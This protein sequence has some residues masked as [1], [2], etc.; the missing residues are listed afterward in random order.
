MD[1]GKYICM[2]VFTTTIVTNSTDFNKYGKA[3]VIRILDQKLKGIKKYP[4]DD[5]DN[6]VNTTTCKV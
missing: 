3:A 6:E 2:L 1:A 4:D 5:D